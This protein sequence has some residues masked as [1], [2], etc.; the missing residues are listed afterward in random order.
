MKEETK[1]IMKAL[2]NKGLEVE[3][4]GFL[5]LTGRYSQIRNTDDYLRVRRIGGNWVTVCVCPINMS[6]ADI[7]YRV[8]NLAITTEIGEPLNYVVIWTARNKVDTLLKDFQ[9]YGIGAKVIVRTV[10]DFLKEL[11]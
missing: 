10:P 9:E 2:K 3:S 6:I 1:E 7:A 5:P 8:L 4:F 11:T